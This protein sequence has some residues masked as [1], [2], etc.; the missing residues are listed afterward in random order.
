MWAGWVW[1]GVAGVCV[2]EEG[3]E[4][5]AGAGRCGKVGCEGRV[6]V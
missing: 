3:D 4:F 5:G 6:R 1:V 2:C